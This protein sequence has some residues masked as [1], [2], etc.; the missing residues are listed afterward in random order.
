[1]AAIVVAACRIS[2]AADASLRIYEL[3]TG[4]LL[5]ELPGHNRPTTAIAVSS[6]GA[7]ALTATRTPEVKL[8][9]VNTGKELRS[10]CQRWPRSDYVGD[11]TSVHFVN[12]T[13][14][15]LITR[16]LRGVHLWNLDSDL[17]VRSFKA[18]FRGAAAAWVS[19]DQKTVFASSVVGVQIASWNLLNGE[20]LS[21]LSEV[22]RTGSN[23]V[24][25]A[26]DGKPRSWWE[27]DTGAAWPG[28]PRIARQ[29]RLG[30]DSDKAILSPDGHWAVTY[31]PSHS[32]ATKD[33][34]WLHLWETESGKLA[35]HHAAVD[36]PLTYGFGSSQLSW[37]IAFSSDSRNLALGTRQGGLTIH[38]I[39][40]GRI[41]RELKTPADACAHVAFLPDGKRILTWG[42]KVARVWDVGS[43]EP[44]R[45]WKIP[46]VNCLTITADG[47]LLLVGGDGEFRGL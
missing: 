46:V 41:L 33:Y 23:Y 26:R 39:P 19:L 43:G 16:D 7:F 1:V 14:L 30:E 18:S 6:D 28:S 44:I 24:S 27:A 32:A 8:W 12:G 4:L 9:S 11:G 31:G 38:E 34:Y 40:S 47:R 29:G 10:I 36:L 21:T 5:K 13:N 3:S 17:P 35:W 15:A 2:P 42:D 22:W 20:L 45:T 25:L 37:A